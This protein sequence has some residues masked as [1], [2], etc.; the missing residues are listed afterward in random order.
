MNLGF[1]TVGYD[2]FELKRIG[3]DLILSMVQI[4]SQVIDRVQD[5]AD[6]DEEEF[7]T[8]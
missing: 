2:D 1:S 6:D 4:L 8:A 5:D 7:Q 3:F